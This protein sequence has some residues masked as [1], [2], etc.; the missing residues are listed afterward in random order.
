MFLRP[1]ANSW[2]E[3]CFNGLNQP[4]ML[5]CQTTFDQ[6]TPFLI[7]SVNSDMKVDPFVSSF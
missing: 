6:G 5:E 3:Q 4:N 2:N 7:F 1:F